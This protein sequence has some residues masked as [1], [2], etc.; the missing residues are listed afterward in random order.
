MA[1]T[2]RLSS[3]EPNLQN[4]PVRSDEGK[5]LRKLFTSS[6]DDGVIVSA[7]YS[8]IELRL[9]AHFSKDENLIKSFNDGKDIHAS[10][11]SRVF[12][13]PLDDV[14]SNMR[15]MAKAVNFGI[16]Y[17][18]SEFGL[19]KNV[20][21]TPR[22]AK[23]FIAKY[24]ELYPSVKS[25][26]DESVKLAKE[27]GYASTLLGRRRYIPE[28][29]SSTFVLR[30][31]G[32]RVAMNMPLQGTA[33]DIIKMAMI[34]VQNKMLECNLKSKLIL[35]IHDELIVDTTSDEVD[36]VSNILKQEMESVVKLSVPLIVDVSMGKSWFD[37]K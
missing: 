28:L 26:M 25:Y 4:I 3:R 22:E 33:S 23:E 15:R 2:G 24:F 7:D 27:R 12:D 10:T 11:A 32:E 16:I 19:S 36:I 30:Q 14:T 37:A 13:V 8:Q 9:L 1:S 6:F 5:E 18:I 21:M 20:H 34:N 35:Q 17:G 29:N 31:F